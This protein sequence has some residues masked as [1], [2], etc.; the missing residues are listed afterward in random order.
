[1][2]GSEALRPKNCRCSSFQAERPVTLG[3]R[4]RR[5]LGFFGL[6]VVGAHDIGDQG[7]A[8]AEDI[9][10]QIDGDDGSRAEGAGGRDRHGIDEGAVGQP[11]AAD[12]DGTEDAGQRIRCAHGV[13]EPATR[14]P[15]FV[16]GAQFCR[17]RNELAF[18]ILDLHV[19][20]VAIEL[21]AQT[22]ACEQA[23]AG[24]IEVEEA[25]YFA[26]RQRAGEVFEFVEFTRCVASADD[27]ADRGADDDIWLDAGLDQGFHD[28]DVGPSPGNATAKC[29]CDLAFAHMPLP[30]TVG[31][32]GASD[33]F[34]DRRSLTQCW[35]YLPYHPG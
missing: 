20:E 14:Q 27:G 4:R 16:A 33:L 8:T 6:R 9:A 28:P 5:R 26:A 1:M 7:A 17:H 25:E 21:V 13:D 15:N 24:Q 30:R 3:L 22:G 29:D 23:A 18:Q 34:E 12:I 10:I 19:F 32:L 2:P 35:C 31:C 11:T